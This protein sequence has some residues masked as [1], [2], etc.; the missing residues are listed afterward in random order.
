MTVARLELR[1]LRTLCAIAD[2]GSL[3]RAA[4]ALDL[5][6]PAISKQLGRLEQLLGGELFTRNRMGAELTS[7]GLEVLDEARDILARVD[8]LS[9]R[10]TRTSPPGLTLRL[11]ATITPVLPGLVSRM[12]STHPEV[13]I[14]VQSEYAVDVLLRMLVSREIDAALVLDYPGRELRDT[15]IIASRAFSTEP[16]FVALPSSHRLSQRVEVP[17][18]EL[19]DES[20]FITPDDG[21]GWPQIFYDA[22]ERAGFCPARTHEFLGDNNLQRLIAAGVGIAACQPT[23]RPTYG[24]IVKPLQGS[25]IRYRQ[26]LAWHRDSPAA[27]MA[28]AMRRLAAATCRELIVQAP[29][30]SAWRQRQAKA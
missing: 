9:R 17:L 15:G 1:H 29:H 2:A 12:R 14:M 21:A 5:S 28:P 20:W 10:S 18:A 6:Q 11:G 3:G 26:L 8:A 7:Y 30:Y 4:L 24:V 16:L 23:T 22:C 19:S 27:R 25:P 13:A